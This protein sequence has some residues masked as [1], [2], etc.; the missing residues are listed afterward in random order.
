MI[1]SKRAYSRNQA[2]VMIVAGSSV[3]SPHRVK[4]VHECSADEASAK[5]HSQ[6]IK[7]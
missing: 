7:L 3:A 5:R 2:V 1:K 6:A 4:S